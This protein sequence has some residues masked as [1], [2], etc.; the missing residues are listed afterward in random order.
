MTIIHLF[1]KGYIEGYQ[2]FAKLL[3]RHPFEGVDGREAVFF[4][5]LGSVHTKE[6]L[7]RLE[8]EFRVCKDKRYMD[9]F[10]F[11]AYTVYTYS[12]K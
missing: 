12:L 11:H 9:F 1:S 8:A 5:L 4:G 3:L 6:K 7:F 2:Q 10:K